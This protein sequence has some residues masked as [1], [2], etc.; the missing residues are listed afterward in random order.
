MQLYELTA[1]DLE[2]L[3]ERL[4]A[5]HITPERAI[6][7]TTEELYPEEYDYTISDP[8]TAIEEGRGNCIAYALLAASVARHVPERE[9]FIALNHHRW[10]QRFHASMVTL[11]PTGV[12]HRTELI[13]RYGVTRLGPGAPEAKLPSYD[14]VP[15]TYAYTQGNRAWVV[16][17]LNNINDP[18]QRPTKWQ[19]ERLILPLG[20]ALPVLNHL[21]TANRLLHTRSRKAYQTYRDEHADEMPAIDIPG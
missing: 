4:D 21:I 17:P 6:Y 9:P 8:T 20:L 7:R 5:P 11:A 3:Q 16:T 15:P 2:R 12:L 1:A 10:S 19:N 14:P 18:V 13:P